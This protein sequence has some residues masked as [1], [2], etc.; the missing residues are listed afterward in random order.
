MRTFKFIHVPLIL[1]ANIQWAYV[2]QWLVPWCGSYR[3]LASLSPRGIMVEV[4]VGVGAKS[5]ETL[6][7]IFLVSVFVYDVLW[8]TVSSGVVIYG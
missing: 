3:N 5:Y 6:Q 7:V 4:S 8:F 2:L 1:G